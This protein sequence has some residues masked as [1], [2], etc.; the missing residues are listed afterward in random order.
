MN[1]ESKDKP[2]N[3]EVLFF[4][5]PETTK[6]EEESKGEKEGSHD[7]AK[8]NT[9]KIDGPIRG[10]YHEGSAETDACAMEELFSKQK[11]TKYGKRS[12]KNG[13]EFERYHGIAEEPNRKRL[14][15]DEESL[16]SE[17]RWVEEFKLTSF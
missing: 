2:R 3:K 17:I 10:G 1:S 9:R 13:T 12:K 4:L 6:E 15:I 14:E 7:S 16:A 8:A 11:K 5:C